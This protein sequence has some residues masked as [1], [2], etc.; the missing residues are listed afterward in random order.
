[1]VWALLGGLGEY[2]A[3]RGHPEFA[4]VASRRRVAYVVLAAVSVLWQIAVP[5]A[6]GL[7]VVPAA[8]GVVAW[9]VWTVMALSLINMVRR[10]VAYGDETL[11]EIAD[12]P[13]QYSLRTLLLM[14]VALWLLLLACFP[15]LATGDFCVVRIDKLSVLDD[16]QLELDYSTRASSGTTLLDESLPG[17][18][19]GSSCGAGFPALP[20]RGR[21]RSRFTINPDRIAM[22][23]QEIRSHM[24][25]EQ[26]RTY[27]VVPGKWLYLYDYKSKD[28]T[29]YCYRLTVT[30]G[31]RLGL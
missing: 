26:G 10:D 16:G 23:T 12:R 2:A 24:L 27:R 22:T 25:V 28:G 9:I 13:R 21:S 1:L 11:R 29:R 14:P 4:M 7:L 20:G 31:S 3:S 30:P 6:H 5:E 17:S 8:I 18:G 15:K 19:G